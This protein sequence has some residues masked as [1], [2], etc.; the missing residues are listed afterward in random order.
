MHDPSSFWDDPHHT[1]S[2]SLQAINR[3]TWTLNPFTLTPWAFSSGVGR[4]GRAGLEVLVKK[5][6]AVKGIMQLLW[7]LGVLV[8]I[9][10]IWDSLRLGLLTRA[11]YW[12]SHDSKRSASHNCGNNGKD[13]D[14]ADVEERVSLA[15]MACSRF[16]A[17]L[18][19]TKNILCTVM[20]CLNPCHVHA[21]TPKLPEPSLKM[22]HEPFS[23]E[24]MRRSMLFDLRR[25]RSGI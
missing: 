21:P 5:H 15:G 17:A 22:L 13:H 1:G 9:R 4:A 7:A 10:R 23:A 12:I 11:Q 19:L 16:R 24:A 20:K 14:V 6:A 2:S 8:E 18:Q 25:L 3:D